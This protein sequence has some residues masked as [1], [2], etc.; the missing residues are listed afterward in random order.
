MKT[1]TSPTFWNEVENRVLISLNCSVLRREDECMDS[2][3]PLTQRKDVLKV[4]FNN[5]ALLDLLTL[6]NSIGNLHLGIYS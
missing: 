6:V 2:K 3:F 4:L 5:M 1:A